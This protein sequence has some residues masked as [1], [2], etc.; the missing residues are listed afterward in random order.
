MNLEERREFGKVLNS[1]DGNDHS[2]LKQNIEKLANSIK[3][4]Q[5]IYKYREVTANNLD[6]LKNNRL[7]FSIPEKYDDIFDTYFQLDEKLIESKFQQCSEF[8]KIKSKNN[9][10]EKFQSFLKKY[11]GINESYFYDKV[12]DINNNSKIYIKDMIDIMK[13]ELIKYLRNKAYSICFGESYDNDCLWLK[14]G[15]EHKGYVLEYEYSSRKYI[16][17]NPQQLPNEKLTLP[18]YPV[19]YSQELCDATKFILDQFIYIMLFNFNR[20][21][22]HEFEIKN[23]NYFAHEKIMLIKK[24]QHEHD[25]EWRMILDNKYSVPHNEKIYINWKPSSVTLGVR[26]SEEDKK[27][28]IKFADEAG[29]EKI[30]QAY[31]QGTQIIRKEI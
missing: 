18:I 28:I 23:P 31:I 1:I 11:Y 8:I 19:Y 27:Q 15:N 26:V 12:K 2:K 20:E 30:Y 25:L 21:L 29:I 17:Y 22:A 13:N 24:K 4:P 7:Y 16:T 6:S 10:L 3:H 9:E 5:S 14:Y